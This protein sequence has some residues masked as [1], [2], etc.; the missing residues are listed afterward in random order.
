MDGGTPENKLNCAIFCLDADDSH[1]RMEKKR[2]KVNSFDVKVKCFLL[3]FHHKC[4][5]NEC[6]LLDCISYLISPGLK[7]R[8]F[9]WG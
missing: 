8:Y 7:P 6:T 4:F 2:K 1:I 9:K 5:Q 3:A